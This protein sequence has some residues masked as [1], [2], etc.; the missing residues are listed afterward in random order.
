[1]VFVGNTWVYHKDDVSITE[2]FIKEKVPE[3]QKI[4]FYN[5]FTLLLQDLLKF[6]KCRSI[7]EIKSFVYII[8]ITHLLDL[9]YKLTC[10][11]YLVD[12]YNLE[13]D[14]LRL[15]H[16]FDIWVQKYKDNNH[17]VFWF[18][19]HCRG[20]GFTYYSRDDF[21][22]DEDYLAYLQGE[23]KFNDSLSKLLICGTLNYFM[24]HPNTVE[25]RSSDFY[26]LKRFKSELPIERLIDKY[27][28]MLK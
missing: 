27:V 1:M 7:E 20:F 4:Y 9:T 2:N 5:M 21:N 14:T 13:W 28:F 10:N 11:K 15:T 23:Y 12:D 16:D 17:Y 22:S 3:E 8:D 6:A 19:P 18:D 24:S 25:Y 26:I